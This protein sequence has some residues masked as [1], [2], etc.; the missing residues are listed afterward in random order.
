MTRYLAECIGTFFL[1][2]AGT[3]AIM[4]D[5]LSDGS[6]GHVG[7]ALSFGLVVMAAI[8]A[9]GESSGAHINPAVSI[10]FRLAKR[11]STKDCL[12]YII[13]Q[14]TGAIAASF[15]LKSLHPAHLS[16]GETIP[17]IPLT[18]AFIYEVLLSFFLM[19][20]ILSVATGAKEKG[21]VAALAIG[22]TV[23]LEALFAGPITGASMNP[24]R[25]LGPALVSGDLMDLWIYLLA[26]T[27][28]ACL[29]V[30]A[31]KILHSQTCCD[32][33]ESSCC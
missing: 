7:I 19:F 24:A 1:V 25:S 33:A 6:I 10:A 2:F 16:L 8:Y 11:L 29:A 12:A 26:P 28:G 9:F 32:S 5:Q 15:L 17:T 31:C 30:P 4:A 20:V 23:A 27:L 14:C 18:G 22:G 21:L 3:G 13:A